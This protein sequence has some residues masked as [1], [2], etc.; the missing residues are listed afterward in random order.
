MQE[1]SDQKLLK[2]IRSI[3]K[4]FTPLTNGLHF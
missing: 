1:K 2:E 3:C 4:M